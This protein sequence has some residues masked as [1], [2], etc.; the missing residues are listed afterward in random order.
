LAGFSSSPSHLLSPC[1][2]EKATCWLSSD[3]Q[4][5]DCAVGVALALATLCELEDD[6]GASSIPTPV[7]KKDASWFKSRACASLENWVTRDARPERGAWGLFELGL[8]ALGAGAVEHLADFSRPPSE[9][10]REA[11]AGRDDDGTDASFSCCCC[12]LTLLIV[13]VLD[14]FPRS[15]MGTGQAANE[16]V[17]HPALI[18]GRDRLPALRGLGAVGVL[19]LDAG[20]AVALPPTSTCPPWLD[21]D[22]GLCNSSRENEACHGHGITP[23]PSQGALDKLLRTFPHLGDFPSP[24]Q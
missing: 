9:S 14:L 7:R 6:R 3:V 1:P 10:A 18:L 4:S 21:R 22:D 16:G 24:I 19:P 11:A 23:P 2:G 13:L 15:C 8:P 17:L 5:A 20:R 12:L